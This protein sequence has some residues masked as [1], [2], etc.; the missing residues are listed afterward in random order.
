MPHPFSKVIKIKRNAEFTVAVIK[1][2]RQNRERSKP[3]VEAL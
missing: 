3:A 1:A 2:R